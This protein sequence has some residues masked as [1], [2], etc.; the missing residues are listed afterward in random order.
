MSQKSMRN[1][2]L[3]RPLSFARIIDPVS[4]RFPALSFTRVQASPSRRFSR[5]A[6]V[7]KSAVWLAR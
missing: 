2:D 5:S 6:G 3:Q 4:I 1:L 7:S